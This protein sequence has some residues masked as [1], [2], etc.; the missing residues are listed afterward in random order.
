M[1][2]LIS[3]KNRTKLQ[4]KFIYATRTRRFL[5]KVPISGK[6][7]TQSTLRI[8][9]LPPRCDEIRLFGTKLEE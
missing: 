6:I 9:A 7:F 5:R 2:S 4:K 3:S 1:F 8:Y